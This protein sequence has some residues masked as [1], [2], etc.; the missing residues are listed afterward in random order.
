MSAGHETSSFARKLGIFL[1]PH[2]NTR[3]SAV[4]ALVLLRILL[5]C[6]GNASFMAEPEHYR[7]RSTASF[8]CAT[9][10]RLPQLLRDERGVD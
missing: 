9:S 3:V 2:L 5:V 6:G 8:P 1:W 4:V 10:A 7:Y